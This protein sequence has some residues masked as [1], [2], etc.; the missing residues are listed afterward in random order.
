MLQL[1]LRVIQRK[2]KHML[3]TILLL[4]DYGIFRLKGLNEILMTS[5][6]ILVTNS[7]LIFKIAF[8]SIIFVFNLKINKIEIL[9]DALIIVLE[10]A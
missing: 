8:Y 5:N 4:D 9:S 6:H 7:N 2:A 1:A 3:Y 10:V